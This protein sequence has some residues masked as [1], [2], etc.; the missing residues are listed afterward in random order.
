MSPLIIYNDYLY[1]ITTGSAKEIVHITNV[2]KVLDNG[3]QNFKGNT[4]I[5][6]LSNGD[7]EWDTDTG[8]FAGEKQDNPWSIKEL[9]PIKDFPEFFL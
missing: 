2:S 4:L 3:F 1:E 9:G 6:D 5:P 8:A 7:M